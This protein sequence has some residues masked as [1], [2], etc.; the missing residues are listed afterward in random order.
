M[1][2]CV[3]NYRPDCTVCENQ[4]MQSWLYV[5]SVQTTNVVAPEQVQQ[6]TSA[7]VM[8]PWEPPS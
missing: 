8:V 4:Y 3:R 2:R 7:A 6:Q 1:V 5:N